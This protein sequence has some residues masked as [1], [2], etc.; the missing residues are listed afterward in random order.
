L[1]TTAD[2]PPDP[3]AAEPESHELSIEVGL[4][5]AGEFTVDGE[6][7]DSADS[8]RKER[9]R[10]RRPG[11]ERPKR[12]G[13]EPQPPSVEGLSLSTEEGGE[14]NISGDSAEKKERKPRRGKEDEEQQ[15]KRSNSRSRRKARGRDGRTEKPQEEAGA[16]TA[17]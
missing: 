16:K 4:E 14:Q 2:A 3:D 10:R 1:T 7:K 15:G 8:Q 12:P 9:S 11:S 5:P 6:K 17:H 13:G